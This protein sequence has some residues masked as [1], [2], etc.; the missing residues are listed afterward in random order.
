VFKV[1]PRV[2][3]FENGVYIKQW[4][5]LIKISGDCGCYLAFDKPGK[6]AF[7]CH[8]LKALQNT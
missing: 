1:K 8:E 7:D 4:S 3:L 2:L 6:A 5:M